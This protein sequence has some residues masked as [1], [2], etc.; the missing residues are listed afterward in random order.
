MQEVY[1]SS[2]LKKLTR[3]VRT[4]QAG[5]FS[6]CPNAFA[7]KAFL[8]LLYV[9]PDRTE[10]ERRK[11]ADAFSECK[12]LNRSVCKQVLMLCYNELPRNY[13]GC[14]LYL[15]I[16]P[17]GHVIRTTSLARRWLAEGLIRTNASAGKQ[18]AMDEAEHYLDVLFIRGFVSPVEIMLQ[19]TSRAAQYI[20]KSESSS[21]R[22]QEM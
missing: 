18:S 19:A 16:F 9:I 22:L 1:W 10:D 20:M 12:R 2:K 14:L 7:M 3:W 4:I 8:H 5:S 15:T 11:Y 13:R 17:E 6:L 21:P